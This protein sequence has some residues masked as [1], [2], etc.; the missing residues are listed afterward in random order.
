MSI[1]S[2][3]QMVSGEIKI[4]NPSEFRL[5]SSNSNIFNLLRNSY[6]YGLSGLF[7]LIYYQS[8]ILILSYYL[9]YVEVGY[10]GFSLVF[11]TGVCL[12]PSVYYLT[13]RLKKIH[14][15]AKI[16]RTALENTYKLHIKY[17]FIV[18]MLSFVIFVIC[19][20]T[21]ISIVF[22]DK[23]ESALYVLY[24]L[25]LYI[26][27]KFLTLNSDSIMHIN[28]LIEM[29]VKVMGAAAFLNISINFILIPYF[30][31]MGAVAST[32]ITELFLLI[33]FHLILR[34]KMP[35]DLHR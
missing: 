19:I 23:Y 27:I 22:G 30:S 34:K 20:K 25:S 16:D 10:Y 32:I 8:D 9:D 28:G 21:F 26:P 14:I 13:F 18:G 35:F 4:E 12:I 17:S 3:K 24:S 1:I 6:P 2:L 7:Y 29:K 31:I 15:L 5:I 11:V 33:S